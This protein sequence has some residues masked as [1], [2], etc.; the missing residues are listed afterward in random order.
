M[1]TIA[2]TH[3]I[4]GFTLIEL[5]ITLFIMSILA[6]QVIPSFYNMI[7]HY[8]SF[9]IIN[10]FKTH[11]SAARHYALANNTSI[12]LCKSSN[13]LDCG[14]SWQEGFIIFEDP[15]KNGQVDAD[16]TIF[17]VVNDPFEEGTLKWR[18][19]GNKAYLQFHP[20]G[21]TYYQNG[22]FTYCPEDATAKQAMGFSVT[23]TGRL[24]LAIDRNGDGVAENSSGKA[25][26][27]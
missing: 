7:E 19:F 9:A 11:V 10:Q 4:R 12:T 25:I 23:V 8:R 26:R 5:V 22:T 21:R 16:E 15:N 17:R 6:F 3:K 24:Q 18:S 14:G 1:D 27:C 13:Q 2:L 20:T